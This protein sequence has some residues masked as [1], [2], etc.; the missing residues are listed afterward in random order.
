MV[1]GGVVFID[2][3]IGFQKTYNVKATEFVCVRGIQ[4]V[5]SFLTNFTEHGS[6]SF[7]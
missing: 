1:S 5:E 7:P 4:C 2:E 3:I 6:V